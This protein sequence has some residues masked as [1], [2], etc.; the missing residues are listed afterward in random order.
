MPSGKKHWLIPC[1]PRYMS[2]Y[3]VTRPW[4]VN[5]CLL[6]NSCAICTDIRRGC[7]NTWGPEQNGCHCEDGVFK[8][9]F[10]ME[11]IIYWTKFHF[12]FVPRVLMENNSALIQVMAC[13]HPVAWT[14]YT[15]F[16]DDIWRLYDPISQWPEAFHIMVQVSAEW[17]WKLC[18]NSTQPLCM[19]YIMDGMFIWHDIFLSSLWDAEGIREWLNGVIWLHYLVITN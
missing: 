7:F 12:A 3:G 13:R 10:W 15:K 5:F 4:G 6:A 14:T 9:I 11:I 18:I 16:H 17:C 2:P 8:C 19:M 1:W